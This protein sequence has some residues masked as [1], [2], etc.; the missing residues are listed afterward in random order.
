[1]SDD[2]SNASDSSTHEPRGVAMIYDH[3][4]GVRR[5]YEKMPDGSWKPLGEF[6]I[7]EPKKE[8]E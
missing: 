7:A 8:E 1:M 5:D 4:R 6:P 3:A 2:A